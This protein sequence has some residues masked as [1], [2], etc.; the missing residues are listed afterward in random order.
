MQAAE[1]AESSIVAISK[2]SKDVPTVH[3]NSHCNRD[4]YLYHG[5]DQSPNRSKPPQ[6][7]TRSK[8]CRG[9]SSTHHMYL[10]PDCKAKDS[11]CYDCGHTGHFAQYCE[12]RQGKSNWS[13]DEGKA[14]KM[15]HLRSIRHSAAVS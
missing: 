11:K 9:C 4:I 15:I 6:S 2:G 7:P 10:S 8:H 13:S 1:S 3:N 12:R 14:I 5:R